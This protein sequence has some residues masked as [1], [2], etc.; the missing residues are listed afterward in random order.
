MIYLPGSDVQYWCRAWYGQASQ[1]GSRFWSSYSIL[2]EL[3]STKLHW[4]TNQ[5]SLWQP[6]KLQLATTFILVR[7]QQN[8]ENYHQY[9]SYQRHACASLPAL[10]QAQMLCDGDSYVVFFRSSAMKLRCK[11]R[12]PIQASAWFVSKNSWLDAATTYRVTAN[13]NSL[14]D[15]AWLR[16]SWELS[17]SLHDART[18]TSQPVYLNDAAAVL[19]LTC[20]TLFTNWTA[21][22]VRNCGG[23]DTL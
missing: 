15:T 1:R 19:Y 13:G 16:M 21:Y 8:L 9:Q 4:T 17:A 18:L 12:V 2:L 11:P 3:A 23:S 20:G 5:P 22:S 10:S 7:S 6:F 14:S